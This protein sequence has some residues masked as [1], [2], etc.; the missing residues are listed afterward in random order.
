MVNR[1]E[2]TRSLLAAGGLLALQGCMDLE[3]SD[4]NDQR[5]LDDQGTPDSTETVDGTT[6]TGTE[7]PTP[8][9]K[10]VDL[11]VPR[12][13][14]DPSAL[15]R[16]QHA[17][18]DYLVRDM[19]GNTTLPQH[20][21]LLFLE[22]TGEIPPS[23]DDRE[24]VSAA[25]RSVEEA[26]QWGTASR[27]N[28]L[29]NTGL[30]YT[31]GYSPTYFDR[32]GSD[33]DDSVDMAPPK[34]VLDELGESTS[35]ADTFD[36][37]L[38]LTSDRASVCLAAEEAMFGTVETLNG[39][40]INH[41]LGTVFD[42]AERRTGFVGA[43]LPSNRLSFDEIPEH[44]PMSM[45]FKSGF[46]DNQLSESKATISKGP[47]A[48]GTIQLVSR[49]DIDLSKWYDLDETD[50]VQ[51]MFSPEHTPEEVGPVGEGLGNHSG[52]TEESVKQLDQESRSG[53]PV[54]HSEKVAR[55]RDE[56]FDPLILRRSESIATDESVRPDGDKVGFN[57]TS[58]QRSIEDFIETREAMEFDGEHGCVNGIIDFLETR[59]RAVFLIPPRHNRALPAPR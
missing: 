5:S 42:I 4:Q 51:A 50:R 58:V 11:D 59:R 23:N 52:I 32:F 3:S 2:F 17:W 15:P 38:L 44:S 49:L 31:I 34:T 29:E 12:G 28:A 55:A 25:L 30:L 33:L 24:T 7:T 39:V 20:Q 8:T 13:T 48:G 53:C 46:K 37:L 43:P 16:E 57:F 27:A 40:D 14:D 54:G 47:F 10:K 18:N 36:A 21:V 26:F 6:E 45:G 35:K 56:N 41:R 9:E 22:Y 19:N 1:R